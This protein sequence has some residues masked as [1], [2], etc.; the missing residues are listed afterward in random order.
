VKKEIDA[1]YQSLVE[2]YNPSRVFDFDNVQSSFSSPFWRFM[3]FTINN[4]REAEKN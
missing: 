3:H 4:N 1:N 2:K